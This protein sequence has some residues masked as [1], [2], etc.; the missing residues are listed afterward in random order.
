MQYSDQQE[1]CMRSIQQPSSAMLSFR[2]TCK[3]QYDFVR[4]ARQHSST[5]ESRPARDWLRVW[6]GTRLQRLLS[7]AHCLSTVW[8]LTLPSTRTPIG[9]DAFRSALQRAVPLQQTTIEDVTMQTTL[10][11][12]PVAKSY[13]PAFPSTPL[14]PR[15]SLSSFAIQMITKHWLN[16]SRLL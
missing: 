5:C 10:R 6:L 8:L 13:T 15:N 12:R 2:P 16:T 1:V 11:G 4:S 14:G 3:D 7:S 9:K